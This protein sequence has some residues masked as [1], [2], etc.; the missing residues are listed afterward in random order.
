MMNFKFNYRFKNLQFYLL[1]IKHIHEFF[2]CLE[3]YFKA[4]NKKIYLRT[5]INAVFNVF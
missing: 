3:I 4:V 5:N 1:F 2:Y